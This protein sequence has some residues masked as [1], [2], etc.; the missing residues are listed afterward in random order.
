MLFRCTTFETGSQGFSEKMCKWWADKKL[1]PGVRR[2]GVVNA[3]GDWQRNSGRG[4]S[5]GAPKA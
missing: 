4:G 1:P 3:E 5:Q 2:Q